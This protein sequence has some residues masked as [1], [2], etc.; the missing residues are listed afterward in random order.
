SSG[1]VKILSGQ[2]YFTT[3]TPKDFGRVQTQTVTAAIRGTEFA[4][5][6]G[7]D[8]TTVIT[9]IEGTVDA[10]NEFGR[11]TVSGGEEAVAAPG[12]APQRRILVRPRDAV[13]W[14]LYYPQV[15]G[16]ADAAR[17]ASAGEGGA[18]VARAAT[19]LSNGQVDQART[20]IEEARAADSK[21][22]VALALAS[23]VAL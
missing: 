8:G 6:V 12:R 22:P 9:M 19:A 7:D 2:S 21:D 1:V 16:G 10:S 14:S 23:V 5:G 4:V 13:A 11:V 15:L 17:L 20:L 3:R 18:R